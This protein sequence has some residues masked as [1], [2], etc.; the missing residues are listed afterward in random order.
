MAQPVGMVEPL[1][2][3]DPFSANRP[4]VQG[5]IRIALDLHDLSVFHLNPK[6]APAVVH[7]GAIGFNDHFLFLTAEHEETAEEKKKILLDT[8]EHG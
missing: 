7:P 5:G 8:D 4:P 3:G 6:P 1:H 2:L